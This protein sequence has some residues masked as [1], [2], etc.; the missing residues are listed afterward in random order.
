MGKGLGGDAVRL[1]CGHVSS[2]I[3]IRYPMQNAVGCQRLVGTGVSSVYGLARSRAVS[4]TFYVF[5]K[6]T[7][8]FDYLVGCVIALVRNW[9]MGQ[10]DSRMGQSKRARRRRRERHQETTHSR[11]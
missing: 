6:A 2:W 4:E 5:I 10:E 7:L 9:W 11:E 8:Q 3:S 1:A